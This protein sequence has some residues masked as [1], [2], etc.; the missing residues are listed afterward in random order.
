MLFT[1]DMKPVALVQ[2]NGEPFSF[3]CDVCGEIDN[4]YVVKPGRNRES[5]A[6][7]PEEWSEIEDRRSDAKRP[8]IVCCS[9][10][11]CQHEASKHSG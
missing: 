8:F 1:S 4:G 3:T 5:W 6:V 7:L 9:S 10:G 2:N 11:N